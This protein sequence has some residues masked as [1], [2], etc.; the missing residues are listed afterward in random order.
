MVHMM[1][2]ALLAF[3][4]AKFENSIRAATMESLMRAVKQLKRRLPGRL[5]HALVHAK[6]GPAPPMQKLW[7]SDSIAH[8]LGNSS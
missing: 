3:T 8:E 2:R 6:Q 1:R 7:L 5:R 4:V